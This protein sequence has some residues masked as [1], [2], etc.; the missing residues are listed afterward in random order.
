MSESP[1]S[2]SESEDLRSSVFIGS[3]Y[4]SASPIWICSGLLAAEEH[5]VS[6]AEESM[7]QWNVG[8]EMRDGNVA[9]LLTQILHH[10]S[11][12]ASLGGRLAAQEHCPLFEEC[13]IQMAVYL[14]LR[15]K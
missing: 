11:P 14:A 1:Y 13:T 6:R 8:L 5:G 4:E 12:M 10:E 3:Y 9:P 15:H 7:C 2:G